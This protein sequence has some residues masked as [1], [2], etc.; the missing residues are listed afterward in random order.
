MLRGMPRPVAN[1]DT[2]PFWDA[3]A[4]G[5]FIVERCENGHFRYP[6]GPM[7]PDCQSRVFEWVTPD[8]QPTLYSWVVSRHPVHGVLVDQVPYVVGMVEIAPGARMVANVVDCDPDSLRGDMPLRLVFE[9][10]E[11]GFSLPNFTPADEQVTH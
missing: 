7:C 8:A 3:C 5:E 1:L 4:R 11:D 2:A 9:S 10:D 6:P